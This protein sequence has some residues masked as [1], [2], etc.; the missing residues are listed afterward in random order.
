MWFWLDYAGEPSFLFSFRA[1]PLGLGVGSWGRRGYAFARSE[2]LA[3]V[4]AGQSKFDRTNLRPQLRVLG[5]VG[6]Q[7]LENIE[8]GLE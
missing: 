8:G 1:V 2:L 4:D 6:S 3:F 5:I 7:G